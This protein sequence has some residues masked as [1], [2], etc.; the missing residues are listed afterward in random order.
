VQVKL[1]HGTSLRRALQIE[2]DGFHVSA[3]GYLGPGVYC[4]DKEKA[5]GYAIRRTAM[6]PQTRRDAMGGLLE[7]AVRAH[8]VKYTPAEDR[9]W[10][11]LGYDAC[12]SDRTT[13]SH[14][15]EWCIKCP[16]QITV[17]HVHKLPI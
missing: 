3:G 12:R 13:Q 15:M 4:A 8:N 9:E 11:S 10:Q 1:F 6:D 5:I 7:L 16:R 2:K 14:K 17:L